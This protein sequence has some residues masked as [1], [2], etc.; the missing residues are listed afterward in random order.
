MRPTVRAVLSDL[1]DTLF[2]HR[3]AT[4]TALA[5]VRHRTPAFGRWSLE[6]L[7]RR[8]GEAL[9]LLHLDVL[10]GRVPLDA[11]RAERF[12]RLLVAAGSDR[13]A[14]QAARIAWQYRDAYETSWQ[15]V[16]GATAFA[17]AVR[18]AG[19]ALVV[20]TNNVV[21]EQRRKL[22]HCALTDLVDA[23][24][25]S[26]EVGAWKPDA[27]IFREAIERAGVSADE[28]VMLGD[29]WQSDVAGARAVGVRAVWFNRFGAPSP[30]PAVP[31]L[32]ALD[33]AADA[34]R[35]ILG[36]EPDE[37]RRSTS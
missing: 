6:E 10:A 22:A 31:E 4:R 26:E 1:D 30:D 29:G 18:E 12:H 16:A 13:P 23:L 5:E 24:V 14:E 34:L 27:R 21:A 19:L 35:V 3:H 37:V 33:P 2:D 36:G 17:R 20:V 8:H 7:E 32:R 11:A 25:T 28:T 9:E 15:P